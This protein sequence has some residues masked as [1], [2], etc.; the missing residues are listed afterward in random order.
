MRRIPSQSVLNFNIGRILVWFSRGAASAVA[1]K[2]AVEK[3]RNDKLEIIYCDTSLNE[4]SDNIRFHKDVEQWIQFPIKTI[5]NPRF[6]TV[7]EVFEDRK[8]ISGIGGAPC[9]GELKRAPRIAYQRPEDV[10]IFGYTIDELERVKSFEASNPDLFLEWILIENQLTKKGCFNILKSA[11][12]QRPRTYDIGLPN[13]NCIGCAKMQSPHGWNLVRQYYPDVF[14]K[15]VEQ[16]KRFGAKLVKL[17]GERI[18][19]HDLPENETEK[20]TENL[21]CGP[22]CGIDSF[23][24]VDGNATYSNTRA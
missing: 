12:I 6:A 14:A 16:S 13:A 4:D 2:L 18:F 3:Y 17:K 8:Y 1:A 15:R 23:P 24:L 9:T 7:E 20:L 10:H 19:L 22:Q 5:R 11:K 21:S